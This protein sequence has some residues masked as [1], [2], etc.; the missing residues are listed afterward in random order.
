MDEVGVERFSPEG[1]V[2]PI[3]TRPYDFVPCELSELDPLLSFLQTNQGVSASTVFPRGTMQPDGRLDLCKQAIGARGASLVI[4]ALMK[5]SEVAHILLGTNALKNVGA[6]QV[7]RLIEGSPAV[8][9]VYLGCND[10]QHEGVAQ[11]SDALR[12]NETVKAL[13]LKRNPVGIIGARHL[14]DMLLVNHTLRTL[15]LV[16]TGIGNPGLSILVDALARRPVPIEQLYLGG[17]GTGATGAAIITRLIVSAGCPRYLSL[18]VSRLGDDG[19]AAL[20]PSLAQPNRLHWLSLASGGITGTGATHLAKALENSQL[21]ILELTRAPS[22][23][24]LGGSSNVI[25]DVGA[26]ALAKMLETNTCMQ[27]LQLQCNSIGKIG[28][29]ALRTVLECYNDTLLDLRIGSGAPKAIRREIRH[30]LMRNRSR[31]TLD[32]CPADILAIKSV[33]R[34]PPPTTAGQATPS[35]LKGSSLP[36]AP[37]EFHDATAA[38]LAT[39]IL[40]SRSAKSRSRGAAGDGEEVDGA[41]PA[42]DDNSEDDDDDLALSAAPMPGTLAHAA[43]SLSR[44]T[45]SGI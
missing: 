40:Q 41:G 22:T 18:A 44:A 39:A 1:I 28:A 21:R 19:C 42:F 31:R 2:C 27:R 38:E 10:I 32:P 43:E 7:A 23:G 26:C 16:N 25:G 3:I 35:T 9:T 8:S 12:R 29:K 37:N 13:W 6:Q 14:A 30:L 20:A 17:N 15:D 24:A 34:V 11:L 4:D 5:N 45:A 33:Y 36:Y